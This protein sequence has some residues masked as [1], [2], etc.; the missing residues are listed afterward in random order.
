MQEWIEYIKLLAATFNIADSIGA[1]PILISLIVNNTG[2]FIF[3]LC[4]M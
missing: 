1:A 2:C 4:E 3:N